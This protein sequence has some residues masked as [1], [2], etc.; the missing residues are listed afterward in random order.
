VFTECKVNRDSGQP[1]GGGG[2]SFFGKTLMICGTSFLSCSSAIESV[3]GAIFVVRATVICSNCSWSNCNSKSSGGAIYFDDVEI[4]SDASIID[5]YF[6][7]CHVTGNGGFFAILFLF[8]K[9]FCR[10]LLF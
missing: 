5:C 3:G 6:D 4:Q 2:V 8:E 7:D 9:Q 10:S 1:Y